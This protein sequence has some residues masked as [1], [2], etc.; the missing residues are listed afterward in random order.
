MLIEA[1]R[2]VAAKSG[3]STGK[4]YL[5]GAYG[6]Y[7]MDAVG[8]Q[9]D[10]YTKEPQGALWILSAPTYD[11]MFNILWSAALAHIRNAERLGYTMPGWYSERSITWYVREDWKIEGI[12]PP[13][14]VGQEQQHGAA[15]RHAKYMLITIDEAPGVEEARIRSAKGM[16]SGA[17]NKLLLIGNPTEPQSPFRDEYESPSFRNYTLSA[18]A[19]PNV[20][21][22]KEIIGGAASHLDIDAKVRDWCENRG[23]FQ[24]GLVEPDPAHFDFLYALHPWVGTLQ[25]KEIPDPMPHPGLDGQPVLGHAHAEISVFRP[26]RRF[27]SS[28][29]GEFPLDGAGALFTLAH[30]ERGVRLWE[31]NR[32]QWHDERGY[33]LVGYD[34]I[35]VDPA[36]YG[37]DDAIA[38]PIWVRKDG[39]GNI[40]KRC[41]RLTTLSKGDGQHLK[42]QLV[43]K[44]GV[45]PHYVVDS[46]GHGGETAG[47]LEQHSRTMNVTRF[48]SSYGEPSAEAEPLFVNARSAA[49]WRASRLLLAGRL[50]L[51]PDKLLHQ[52][53]VATKYVFQK[54]RLLIIP[55]DKIKE[56]IRRSPDRA[57]ALVMGLFEH[58]V[59]TEAGGLYAATGGRSTRDVPE[60]L[61]FY[62]NHPNAKVVMLE[63]GMAV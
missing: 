62:L 42:S 40:Y 39:L 51:P 1:E 30:I 54:D 36:E 26:D 47:M 17:N 15:G 46:I 45:T 61:T 53:L 55:K 3:N 37:G 7:Y 48:K 21:A 19:H 4:S 6:V 32:S 28:V 29:M 44:Y 23:P 50:E 22:R 11:G 35:G 52:E 34:V 20:E 14:T 58:S 27:L 31:Q 56:E 59:E 33:P 41:D 24:P 9:L 13:K 12:S 63:D 5:E 57:D 8:A 43:H 2:R 16:A 18:L 49:Y 25:E 10:P 38:A 60:D